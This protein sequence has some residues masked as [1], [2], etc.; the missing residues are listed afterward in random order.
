MEVEMAGMPKEIE[1]SNDIGG[2]GQFF[3]QVE[4]WLNDANAVT[5]QN[6]RLGAHARV[7]GNFAGVTTTTLSGNP[8]INHFNQ[9]WRHIGD[10]GW[11]P[12]ITPARVNSQLSSA[13]ASA[14]APE[15][16]Q[17]EIRLRWDCRERNLNAADPSFRATVSV[18]GGEVWIDIFSPRAPGQV[19][20]PAS[21]SPN[22]GFNATSDLSPGSIGPFTALGDLEVAN[23]DGIVGIDTSFDT[24][25]G[26]IVMTEGFR[27]SWSF[28]PIREPVVNGSQVLTGLSYTRDSWRPVPEE[29]GT[30]EDEPLHSETGYLLW[31]AQNGQAH[32]VIATP[33]GVTLLA[34]ARDV[35]AGSN[36]L[37]FEADADS[38]DPL[39]GGILSNPIIQSAST[40]TIRF[41]STMRIAGDGS[42][43]AYDDA[44]EQLREDQGEVRHTDSNSLNRI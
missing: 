26:E 3:R 17:L 21:N 34:V 44:A 2:A 4:N 12:N 36:E 9:H 7:V 14:L 40:R 38:D 18:T 30:F 10:R 42:S 39:L 22:W 41:T 31:D 25:R 35:D 23:Y 33:R 20:D 24:N 13:F 5:R 11:W 32:R 37:T 15:N 1:T 28:F 43:L 8:G 16:G 27:E 19:P 6:N 29:V